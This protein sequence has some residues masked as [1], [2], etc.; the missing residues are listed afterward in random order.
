M[1]LVSKL[2]VI[3]F[4]CNQ[5]MSLSQVRILSI[6]ISAVTTVVS[7]YVSWYD[8]LYNII[9]G[10]LFNIIWRRDGFFSPKLWHIS[11]YKDLNVSFTVRAE[12][13]HTHLL[14]YL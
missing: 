4:V 9:N 12:R 5:N 2:G 10:T 7:Y 6:S 1:L 13:T 3:H 14:N 11:Y 8:Q